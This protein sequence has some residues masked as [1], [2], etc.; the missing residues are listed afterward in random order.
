MDN[1]L[2]VLVRDDS[3]S[4]VVARPGMKVVRD[5]ASAAVR[6][7]TRLFIIVA[8]TRL[9]EVAVR[10]REAN[11]EK[12]LRA[13]IVRDD[14]GAHWLSVTLA[15]AEI[16]SLRNLVVHSGEEVPRRILNAWRQGAQARLIADAHF[17]NDRF[18]VRAC[19]LSTYE[20]PVELVAA[21]RDMPR[22]EF[23]KFEI[24]PNGAFLHWPASDVH[25]DLVSLQA[26]ID[27]AVA[28]RLGSE[29][30]AHDQRFGHG[31][32][33]ARERHGLAQSAIDGVSERQVRRI[34]AG[35]F[36]PRSETLGKLARAHGMTL[37]VYLDEVAS[38][39]RAAAE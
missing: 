9:G 29:R 12:H 38:A 19:D 39:A 26:A 34:E 27:P 17:A 30:L 11:R 10:V 20:V 22:E 14:I 15:D 8:A 18:L 1:T 3:A 7:A 32:R 21:L 23:G 6:D 4:T 25:L 37:P 36:F 28:E 31:V 33:I 16:R 5:P 35:Q 13:L 24:H 2:T